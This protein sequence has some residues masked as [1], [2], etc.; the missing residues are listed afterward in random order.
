MRP[1]ASP[2]KWSSPDHATSPAIPPF[3]SPTAHPHSK[4][5]RPAKGFV[6]DSIKP[7][8]MTFAAA[9]L[10]NIVRLGELTKDRVP[11]RKLLPHIASHPKSHTTPRNTAD[12]PS[13]S[14]RH[15][16]EKGAP[17]IQPRRR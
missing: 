14:S 6:V 8:P 16:E 13:R 1:D 9:C 10:E 7:G 15:K 12:S 11:P 3:P 5:A 2:Q 4:T 17:Y